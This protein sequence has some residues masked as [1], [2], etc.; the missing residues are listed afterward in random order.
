VAQLEKSAK[1]EQLRDIAC[2]R[3]VEN[4]I[5]IKAVFILALT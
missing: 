2:S 3:K 5:K 1:L 4:F